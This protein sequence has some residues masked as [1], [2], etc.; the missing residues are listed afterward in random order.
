[1]ND[2]RRVLEVRRQNTTIYYWIKQAKPR[3]QIV[4]TSINLKPS[5]FGYAAA[6]REIDRVTWIFDVGGFEYRIMNH[7]YTQY[8]SI[9]QLIIYYIGHKNC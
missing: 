4:I 2:T 6:R 3:I 5:I 1:M 7:K 8:R 9:D